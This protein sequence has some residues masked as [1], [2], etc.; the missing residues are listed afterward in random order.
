MLPISFSERMRACKHV[1]GYRVDGAGEMDVLLFPGSL[2]IE[3]IPAGYA[4]TNHDLP[5]FF[6]SC[7]ACAPD[8]VDELE[9]LQELQARRQ[10]EGE[11]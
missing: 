9:T 7:A 8:D 5:G 4:W 3:I 11:E 6:N 10:R 2:Y 1:R